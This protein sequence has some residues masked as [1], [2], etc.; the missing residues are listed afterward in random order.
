MLL[1][2]MFSFPEGGVPM[3]EDIFPPN[4]WMEN[5]NPLAAFGV[6]RIFDDD[7][8]LPESDKPKTD[9]EA[10]P[11]AEEEDPRLR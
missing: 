7:D 8:L 9:D 2:G 6:Y 5:Y 3:K 11:F 10:D 4:W 1:T